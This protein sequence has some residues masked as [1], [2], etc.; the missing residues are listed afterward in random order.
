[1][2]VCARRLGWPGWVIK[3]RAVVL[4]LTRTKEKPWGSQELEILERNAHFHPHTIQRK[5]ARA[6][7]QRTETAIVLKR[8]R[9]NLLSTLDGYSALSLAG[10][11]GIDSHCVGRWIRFGWLMA[12]KRGTDRTALQGGDTWFIRHEQVYRFV[13]S[14]PEEIDLTKVDKLWFLDL[15]TRGKI[16][17]P[18]RNAA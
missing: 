18:L 9:T 4:G 16:G 2:R 17:F 13:L 11:F 15:V 3:K 12:E 1:V 7:Y 6:G 8:R 5:L 10:L 14:H